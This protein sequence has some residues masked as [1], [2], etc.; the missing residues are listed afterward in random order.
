MIARDE[1]GGE[2]RSFTANFLFMCAGYYDYDAG[3][4]PAFPGESDFAGAIVHPQQWPESLDYAGKK[5][6]VIGSGATAVT[7]VP[8]MANTAAQVTMLQR[9]PTWMIERPSRDK[10]AN[11]LRKILPAKIA[12]TLTRRKNVAMQRFLYQRARASP[13]KVGDYLFQHARKR[14]PNVA[15]VETHFRP[16]YSPW[17]QRL[18]LIPDGDMFNALNDG[19]AMVVTDQIERFTSSGITLQ[20]GQKLEADIIVTATG[21]NLVALGKTAISIDGVPTRIADHFNYKGVMFSDIPNMASVF[22]YINAS[23][24]LKADIV[25]D[26]VCRL[27]AEMDRKGAR[28]ANPELGE[29]TMPRLPFVSEFTSGYFTR[30]AA[31]LPAN[32]DRHPWRTVQDYRTETHIL[33]QEPVDDGIMAFSNPLG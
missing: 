12:Y 23:W 20:S 16:P 2:L 4:R 5:V 1:D 15:G 27:L 24:T 22:G 26:Y 33:T 9:T 19:R 13:G 8:V 31:E 14:M 30:A 7:I 3:Y 11:L 6:V 21:L 18:C 28:I 25:C 29:T 10:V 32:G 17:Q